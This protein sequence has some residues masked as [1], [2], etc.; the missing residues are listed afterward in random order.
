MKKRKI[1]VIDDE[2]IIAETVTLILQSRGY[3]VIS[4]PNGAEGLIKVKD[5]HPD[6]ILLDI[7]MPVMN[8]H[9]TCARL[10]ADRNTK[11]IP[12][13]MFT[14]QSERDAV[15]KAY[16]IGANDYILKPFTMVTL[17]TKINQQFGRS[18]KVPKYRKLSWWRRIFRKR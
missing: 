8:G 9:D 10:K 11:K 7:M 12:V 3:E 18:E 1:L 13:I 5:E 4:A 14:G 2:T 17:L 16:Q 6:L 15:L